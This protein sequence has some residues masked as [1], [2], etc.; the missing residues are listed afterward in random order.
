ML[1]LNVFCESIHAALLCSGYHRR[2]WRR[3]RMVSAEETGKR[4]D[5][6]HYIIVAS[7]RP[8]YVV[9]MQTKVK[10]VRHTSF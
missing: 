6:K 1:A 8:R 2:D 7:L 5:Q 4:V 10:M 3:F 9:S